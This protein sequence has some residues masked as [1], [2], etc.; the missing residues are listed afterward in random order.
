MEFSHPYLLWLLPLALLPLVFKRAHTHHYSWIDLLPADP[1]SN[2]VGF[3]LKILAVCILAA[4][5]IG[6]SA[7]H[8]QQQ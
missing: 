2:L 7:P 6:L 4:T 5:I 3:I 1:L 8:S